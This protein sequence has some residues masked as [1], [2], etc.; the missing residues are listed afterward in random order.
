VQYVP[1]KTSE[2][3]LTAMAEGKLHVAGFNT[4]NVP[5][6]VSKCGFVPVC[7]F[8]TADGVSTY[9][10]E[11]IVPADSPIQSVTDIQGRE[12]TLTQPGSNAGFKVPLVLMKDNQLLP[13][14]DFTVRYSLGYEQSI[15]GIAN[16]TYQAAA[17][18]S[19]VLARAVAADNIKKEQ[20][21]TIHKSDTFPT[22]GLGY[23]YNLKPELAAK[24]KDA[25]FSFE[26]KGTGLEREFGGGH[27]AKFVP[28]SYKNDF[29]SVRKIDDAI[30][31]TRPLLATTR[32]GG[33]E[34]AVAPTTSTTQR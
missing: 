19:D 32:A 5:V 6:A 17:V 24:V 13:A 7:N 25:F 16:K 1:Y 12:L 18:A 3:E 22:A 33:S 27:Q 31:S 10:M 20:Y 2:D 14:R 9:Q 30:R 23:V 4:G 11:L 28:V 34:V 21:R 8:A 26:W 29:A 15:A